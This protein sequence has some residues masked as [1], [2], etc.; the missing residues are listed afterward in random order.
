[1]EALGTVSAVRENVATLCLRVLDASGKPPQ[2]N[3]FVSLTHV[4]SGREWRTLRWQRSQQGFLFA[5]LPF[6][7]YSYKA[8]TSPLHRVQGQVELHEAGSRHELVELGD[9]PSSELLK[10]DVSA[11]IAPWRA[12]LAQC[13][14]DAALADSAAANLA[15][16]RAGRLL[17]ELLADPVVVA[18]ATQPLDA[19][20]VPADVWRYLD[21]CA[22]PG[23]GDGRARALIARAR[24]LT[25]TRCLAANPALHGCLAP[26]ATMPQLW[27][28][29]IRVLGTIDSP[30]LDD[31]FIWAARLHDPQVA[32]FEQ[33]AR[34]WAERFNGL[35]NLRPIG[36]GGPAAPAG[37]APIPALPDPPDPAPGG[38]FAAGAAPLLAEIAHVAA[39]CTTGGRR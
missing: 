10:L 6:G 7:T 38:A 2:G 3:V 35:D 15:P 26:E 37:S 8:W 14:L 4:E 18:A 28:A 16:G 29:I 22:P 25:L 17:A 27:T 32:G 33:F 13:G 19:L 20:A 12:E 30:E 11:R 36:R 34:A 5:R 21:A 23:G 31:F 9:T 24:F 39:S 1:M